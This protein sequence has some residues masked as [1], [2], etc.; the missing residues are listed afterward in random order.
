MQRTWDG[1]VAKTGKKEKRSVTEFAGFLSAKTAKHML[2]DMK[3]H[4]KE[5]RKDLERDKRLNAFST[6]KGAKPFKEEKD[7][8]NELW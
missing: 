5:T 8:H 6:F 2:E 7:L 1:M 3:R 4:R